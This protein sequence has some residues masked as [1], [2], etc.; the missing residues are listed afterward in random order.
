MDLPLSLINT[1]SNGL[2]CSTL[3]TT[4]NLRISQIQSWP[5]WN[6]NLENNSCCYFRKKVA[7]TC[8]DILHLVKSKISYL[9]LLKC[10]PK[11]ITFP[12]FIEESKNMSTEAIFNLYVFLQGRELPN[13]PMTR[14]FKGTILRVSEMRL[15]W[16]IYTPFWLQTNLFAWDAR[17]MILLTEERSTSWT[18]F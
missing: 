11:L 1:K 9:P 16:N 18:S 15:T 3:T 17:N 6:Y 4:I 10:D 8:L 12:S 14:K 13:L 5:S 2:I 7:H